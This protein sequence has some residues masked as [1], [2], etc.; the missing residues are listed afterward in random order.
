MIN[1]SFSYR[2]EFFLVFHI[3]ITNITLNG[4]YNWSIIIVL[5]INK[6]LTTKDIY[7]IRVPKNINIKRYRYKKFH[8]HSLKL[9]AL[10]KKRNE[11]AFL[12]ELRWKKNCFF[13]LFWKLFLLD[14]KINHNICFIRTSTINHRKI[15]EKSFDLISREECVNHSILHDRKSNGICQRK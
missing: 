6:Q 2:R 15:I 13:S 3:K 1:I 11:S 14:L 7:I 12:S 9:L 5:L 4:W 10:A 8:I